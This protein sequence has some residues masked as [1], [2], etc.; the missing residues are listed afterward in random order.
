LIKNPIG[1]LR[2]LGLVF[3]FQSR[4][5][6]VQ[7]LDV[8]GIT[9]FIA[10]D[11]ET[12]NADFGSICSIGLVHFRGGIVFK[13][14]TILVDPEDEF[15]PI[16]IR[17]HGIRPEDVAGRPTMAKV[18]PVI[19]AA[20]QDAAFTI[21]L[22]IERHLGG[23]RVGTALGAYPASGWIRCKWRDELGMSF[24]KTEATA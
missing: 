24:A 19:A 14:L 15:D 20:L 10:L 13:S 6:R 12:A 1:A 18:F 7:G 8:P 5:D 4:D 23:R 22:L 11:V 2:A 17:I 16:N 9:D 3:A 21:V